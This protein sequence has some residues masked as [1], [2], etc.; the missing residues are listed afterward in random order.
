M[1]AGSFVTAVAALTLA[2]VATA[3]PPKAAAPQARPAPVVLASADEVVQAPRPVEHS[4]AAPVKHRAMRVTTCRC[5]D[6]QTQ[7]QE[8]P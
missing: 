8:Q 3:E 1:R 7:P 5:G 6:P 2:S 4:E